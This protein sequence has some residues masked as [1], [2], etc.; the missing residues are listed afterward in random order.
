M[1]ARLEGDIL[2][3]ELAARVATLEVAAPPERLLN[4]TLRGLEKLSLRLG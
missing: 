1:M 4:N 2:L 3:S